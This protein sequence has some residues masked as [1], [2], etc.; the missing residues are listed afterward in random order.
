M[1]GRHNSAQW[2]GWA[3]NPACHHD[4]ESADHHPDRIVA[5]HDRVGHIEHGPSAH[6]AG[7]LCHRAGALSHRAGA[8]C[9]RPGAASHRPGARNDD[10]NPPD[11]DF[12]WGNKHDLACNN[13]HGR[14]DHNYDPPRDDHNRRDD[15]NYTLDHDY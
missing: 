1:W 2:A 4:H 8:P 11:Y 3:Q 6:R 14:R 5:D 10:Y 9:H 15:H 13:D 7:A 12:D